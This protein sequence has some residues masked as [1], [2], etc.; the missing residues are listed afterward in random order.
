MCIINQQFKL[1]YVITD[2]V[3]M[4]A[5]YI[6]AISNGLVPCVCDLV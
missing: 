2:L 3:E 1:V 5:F 4:L 6:V